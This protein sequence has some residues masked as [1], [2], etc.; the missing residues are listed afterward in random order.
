MTCRQLGQLDTPAEQEAA[1]TDK[2]GIGS[3]VGKS[4]ERCIDFADGAGIENPNLHPHCSSRSLQAS[5]RRLSSR[6]IGRIDERVNTNS[7][8]QKLTQEFQSLCHDFAQ[9][10]ID[11]RQ[12]AVWLCEAG[13]KTELYWIFASDE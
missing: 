11:S 10:D 7:F 6:R 2:E 12:V 4:S 3:V 1:D 9:E 8:R 5:Q 13:D